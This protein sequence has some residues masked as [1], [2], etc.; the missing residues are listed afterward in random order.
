MYN[1]DT[2]IEIVYQHKQVSGSNVEDVQARPAISSITA[3]TDYLVKQR[4]HL[5]MQLQF[6]VS[7]LT[8][9]PRWPPVEN[10][11]SYFRL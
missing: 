7:T 2:N 6:L 3:I 5:K 4:M 9:T 8:W 11:I 10:K 1:P